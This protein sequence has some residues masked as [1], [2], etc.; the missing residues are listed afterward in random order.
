[1]SRGRYVDPTIPRVTD[2]ARTL[3]DNVNPTD[4]VTAGLSTDRAAADDAGVSDTSTADLAIIRSATDNEPLTDTSSVDMGTPVTDSSSPSDTT[5]VDLSQVF[6]D[7]ASPTD[8]VIVPQAL[9]ADF[10][11]N[12][13]L[14]DE[15]I[16]AGDGQELVSIGDFITITRDVTPIDPLGPT[17]TAN[18]NRTVLE[19]DSEGLTDVANKIWTLVTPDDLEGTTDNP[20]VLKNIIKGPVDALGTS[21]SKTFNRI[22]GPVNTTGLDDEAIPTNIIPTVAY[23]GMDTL[24]FTYDVGWRDVINSVDKIVDQRNLYDFEPVWTSDTLISIPVSTTVTIKAVA[25]ENPFMNAITPVKGLRLTTDL[26]DFSVTPEDAD[27]VLEDGA[28]TITLSRTSGQSVD[29]LIRNASAVD[30]AAIS[31]LRLRA[32]PV[33]IARSIRMVNKD[34]DSIDVN[35]PKSFTDGM[36]WANFNDTFNISEVIL[37]QRFRRL[38][39]IHF[40]VNNGNDTRL[41]QAFEIKLSDR[42]LLTNF[43]TATDND[44]FVEQ[45]EHH[46]QEAGNVHRTVVGCEQIPTPV[47]N[48]FTFNVA[49]LGFNDGVFADRA[50]GLNFDENLFILN[51]SQ[52]NST[53]V[54]A[55]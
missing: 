51:Q 46:I 47:L 44:F 52:L 11:E 10:D 54:L 5:A 29:I 3:D 12:S 21:D 19:A 15:T 23:S 18:F 13:N 17:D 26:G 36:P 27:Y 45:V 9:T 16:D 41:R 39:V 48:P 37:N 1:M 55:L 14:T 24:P 31:N 33:K 20:F 30:P 32:R 2:Q 4:S 35:G 49:G 38:P 50:S 7:G 8:E 53:K 25:S 42:I 34:V 43:N 22:L 6:T 40:E 28:V